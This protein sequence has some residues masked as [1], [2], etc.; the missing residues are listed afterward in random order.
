MCHSNLDFRQQAINKGADDSKS[1]PILFVSQLVGLSMGLDPAK[2]GL[3]R[4][5]V[6]TAPVLQQIAAAASAPERREQA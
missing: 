4:H 5:F 3:N 1:I 2:L 6:D